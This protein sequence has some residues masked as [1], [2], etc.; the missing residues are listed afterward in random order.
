MVSGRAYFAANVAWQ[1]TEA[2][3]ID[4]SLERLDV[5][6]NEANSVSELMPL[7]ASVSDAAYD[8]VE[9]IDNLARVLE[10]LTECHRHR[11]GVP[12]NLSNLDI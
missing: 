5:A 4:Q 1:N 12:L 9:V 8:L 10:R 3:A 6:L 2:N 7:T 11:R